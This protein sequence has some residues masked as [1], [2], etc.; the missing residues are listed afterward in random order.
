MSSLQISLAGIG[1][2]TLVGVVIYNHWM[3]RKNAP[4]QA[5]P[6]TEPLPE[7]ALGLGVSE[8]LEP[9][10]TDDFAN[11]PQP[12]RKAR[13]DGLIDV[14]AMVEVDQPVS[15][16]AALA[17]LPSTRR[18]GTKPFNVEGCSQLNGE[19]EPLLPGRR[20]TAFQA[21]V[22]M[23]NRMGAL[24]EIEF[25][26]FV[27]KTQAFAD[28]VN[29]TATFGEMLE[30]VARAR[31]LDQFASDHDAQLS[32]TLCA[33]AAAWSPGYIQQHA[34]RLGF[35]PGAMPGRM[36]LPSG[37]QGLAPVLSL[38]FDT[39]AAMADDP[40]LSAIREFSLSLDL[41]QIAR[42]D[43]A[44]ERL[45]QSA[46]RLAKDMDAWVTDGAGQVLG[47]EVLDQI[48]ADLGHLYDALD[49][50]ELSAGSLQAR[51]LFS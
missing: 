20:Y 50:R 16:D 9:V 37:V 26:E 25:S 46:S 15:G 12:E 40:T 13:L 18:V 47:D 51:R 48:A 32:F 42:E 28:A 10:L 41:P 22:Q 29:G 39:H 2:L 7:Q 30:Q 45:R 19:W 24:N 27:V 6:Q 33:R 34:G 5:D 31:E 49:Q 8:P 11:L 44:F 43:Q 23:A 35:V 3:S 4:R 36:V 17:A 14:I 21:G 1:G 38:T